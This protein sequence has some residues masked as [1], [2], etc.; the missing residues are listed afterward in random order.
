MYAKSQ[1]G[2]KCQ[3]K[4]LRYHHGPCRVPAACAVGGG[5][6]C[7]VLPLYEPVSSIGRCAAQHAAISIK[8]RS[9]P[10]RPHLT[11]SIGSTI[12]L[13]RLNEVGMRGRNKV[14]FLSAEHLEAQADA[15]TS[16]AKQ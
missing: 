5:Q 7:S 11:P 10:V 9:Y 1:I 8:C 6:R 3:R 15:R 4:P 16:E 14:V 13:T 2:F 12:P